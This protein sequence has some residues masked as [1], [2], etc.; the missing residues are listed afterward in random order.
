M[1]ISIP[2]ADYTPQLTGYTGQGAFR[3]WCQKVLPLVYDDSLS[4][5]ELLNKVVNYLNNVIADV[6]SVENNIE[7][8]N[9]SYVNLQK[10]VNDTNDSVETEINE[11]ET[12]VTTKVR[13]L[14]QFMDNYF[15][16]L[17]VQKEI[18]DKLDAMASS[19]VLTNLF[20]PLIEE[21]APDIITDWLDKNITPTTPM[22]DASLTISGQA[23]DAKITGNIRTALSENTFDIISMYGTFAEKTGDVTFTP[24]KN[25]FLVSGSTGSSS[26]FNN[27]ITS[28]PSEV[29][30]GDK[31]F[32]EVNTTNQNLVLAVFPTHDSTIL[33]YNYLN[34]DTI[35]TIPT[36]CNRVVIRCQ[37]Q[38]NTTLTSGN[39]ITF[40]MFPNGYENN[41]YWGFK[42]AIRESTNAI[43][44]IDQYIVNNRVDLNAILEEGRYRI[45]EDVTIV[46]GPDFDRLYFLS[47]YK[48]N[49]DATRFVFQ[50]F[51]NILNGNERY[52]RVSDSEGTFRPWV[53]VVGLSPKATAFYVI[54]T[55]LNL[56]NLT[57]SGYY[58][59]SEN[60]NVINKPAS[61][62][63]VSHV[64]C[65]RYGALGDARF[66][67]QTVENMRAPYD[68][69]WYRY[70]NFNGEFTSPWICSD[71]MA[72]KLCNPYI[73]GNQITLG[74][75]VIPGF[76]IINY[77]LDVTDKP[78]DLQHPTALTVERF[79]VV[80]D[81]RFIKQTVEDIMTYQ[82][83]KRYYRFANLQGTFGPWVEQSGGGEINN[84]TY[85]V[86]AYP[87]ITTDSNSYLA[88]TGTSED[89]T[90]SILAM[91]ES[92][93]VCRLGKGNY[94]VKNLNM[95]D[96][97]SIIGCGHDTKVI[98]T[99]GDGYAIKMNS[100]CTVSNLNL[101]GSTTAINPSSATGN[102]IG[103]LWQGTYSTDSNAP[104][105]GF[106]NDLW[107][108]SFQGSG[109]KF[110]DTGYGLSNSLFCTNIY[111]WN[112][113]IGAD[114]RYF[115]EFNKFTNC[116]ATHCYIGCRNNGGS[117]LF[118]NCDFSQ[119]DIGLL[120]DNTGNQSPNNTHSS[121]IGCIFGHAGNNTGTGIKIVNCPNG[122]VFSGCQIFYS[123][124]EINNSDGIAF[125]GCNIG[126]QNCDITV[127]GGNLV[128][129]NSC[130]FQENPTV[131]IY[132]NTKVKFNACYNRVTGESISV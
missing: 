10:F 112:C 70:A 96:G 60:W 68:G 115:S 69:V 62:S 41:A 50:V 22:V 40:K 8:L 121:A 14:E 25:G 86:T 54:G 130:V 1:S 28:L 15:D 53:E 5:Y 75:I 48:F 110:N 19:G 82:S 107:I 87:S 113:D 106:C 45:D 117:N 36:N 58:I 63:G 49:S 38:A 125:V 18:N 17:D 29:K 98:L 65:E 111:F 11:F 42:E 83:G 124:M 23:A 52:M 120:M 84:Y 16:N 24:I 80:N 57:Y 97:S 108:D 27:V 4:Y 89:V 116:K 55:D 44:S 31:V 67:K 104:V 129:Y 59:I 51:E 64:K 123:K 92:T 35:L 122:F 90:A 12:R 128:M 43:K 13:E 39:Q 94:Y 126:A 47:V 26:A 21:S 85:N 100:Y 114:I 132:A 109:I 61:M 78:M 127:N 105:K 119:S 81:N 20:R 91:L 73:N 74:D 131:N 76:Y 56:N 95:P 7:Q 118:V 66:I 30:P 32:F 103:I 77:G 46:N 93:G 6:A 33:S 79:S 101:V 102:R 2:G 99:N 9:T 88:P 71:Q 3:F 72:P 34:N 37:V